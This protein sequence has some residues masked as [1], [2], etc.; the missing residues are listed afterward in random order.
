MLFTC[1]PYGAAVRALGAL[2]APGRRL[3]D[4]FAIARTSLADP[5]LRRLQLAWTAATAG[6]AL[7]A[8]AFG[9]YAYEVG[10]AAAVGLI[11]VVQMVSA[12]VCG[13]PSALLGDR[14]RRERVLAGA[15][16][17]AALALTAATVADA[18]GAP[19]ALVFV[20]AAVLAVLTGTTYPAQAALVPLLARSV[21]EVTAGTAT[22]GLLRSVSALGAPVVAGLVLLVAPSTAV[23]VVAALAYLTAVLLALGLPRTD[24]VRLPPAIGGAWRAMAAGFTAAGSDRHT[25]LVLSALAGH[26]VV[27]GAMG[28]L[29][30]VLPLE[31]LDLGSS[32][33]GLLL[34]VL[35]V[36]GLAGA[37]GA[38]A[39]AGR[40][41]LAGPMGLGLA[42]AALPLLLAAALPATAVVLVA[43]VAVGAGLSLVSVVGTSLL[44][45]AVRDDVLSRV[46]GV[47]QT[48]R[49]LSM[50]LGAGV[51]PLLLGAFG[52][53]WTLAAIG[54]GLALVLL[55]VRGGLRAI[56]ASSTVPARQL[57]L[58]L[59]A[60]VFASLPPV[61]LERLA[62]RLEEVE[63][64]AGTA[65]V[66]EGEAAGEVYLVASG[67]LAVEVA[68]SG[69]VV[70]RI[71]P[72]EVFG[73]MALLHGAP[74][75]ATV[76]ASS[77]CVLYRLTREEF[78][79]AVSGSPESTVRA[80][81]LV[82]ARLDHRR[83]VVDRTG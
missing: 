70:D 45:R 49:A 21:G 27:R 82:A 14:Y 40:R 54:A 29:L 23:L 80:Q 33:V 26:S 46:L 25:V 2:L 76:R 60:P 61:A 39:L 32:G 24:L 17:L 13:P 59:G 12:A 10:G 38:A 83:R 37:L 36:G 56:D 63:V 79:V 43:V 57:A 50:A 71:V 78:L 4:S 58:L 28:T 18:A 34:A 55:A 11:A 22:A 19:P 64:P 52:L 42:L 31:L 3:T 48:M 66:Q 75:N 8:V 72:G 47:L 67:E 5:V 30:V 65:A 41:R 51:T 9:V 53:R 7:A 68:E 81:D 69:G 77:D 15:A 62:S 20:L 6:E 16:A 73:E 74:R 44:V 1:G 35:A